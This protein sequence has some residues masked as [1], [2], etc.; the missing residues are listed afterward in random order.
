M[1]KT[2]LIILLFFST[3][4]SSAQKSAFNIIEIE[5]KD[6]VLVDEISS[7]IKSELEKPIL[8]DFRKENGPGYGYYILSTNHSTEA[9]K[10]LSLRFVSG[11]SFDNNELES[12]WYPLF[13]TFINDQLI[14][15][16]DRQLQ[17][18]INNYPITRKS[19]KSLKKIVEES[20]PKSIK[21][22]FP[23]DPGDPN[24][25]MKKIKLRPYQVQNIVCSK[26]E[27]TFNYDGS[28]DSV[29]SGCPN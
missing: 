18:E 27:I 21:I 16:R 20:L 1:K 23:K 4:F 29:I 13:Y 8:V 17:W 24:S 9:R 26:L 5:L 11:S 2:R 25:K 15:I 12:F 3:Y 6:S 7:F 22:D 14:F 19:K 10:S 28:A